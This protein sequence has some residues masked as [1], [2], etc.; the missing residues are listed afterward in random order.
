MTVTLDLVAGV[1]VLVVVEEL[2]GEVVDQL[3]DLALLPGVLALIKVN[4]V[5]GLVEQLSTSQCVSGKT[6]KAELSRQFRQK[7]HSGGGFALSSSELLDEVIAERSVFVDA[8]KLP[9]P[10]LQI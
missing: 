9:N 8:C 10:H 7:M 6:F 1:T 2:A 3:A 4:G 5:F